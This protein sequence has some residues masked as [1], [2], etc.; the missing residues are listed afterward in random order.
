MSSVDAGG[1]WHRHRLELVDVDR[2]HRRA[3]RRSCAV[4]ESWRVERAAGHDSSRRGRD[5]RRTDGLHQ[6]CAMLSSQQRL[7]LYSG[8]LL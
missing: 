8:G 5:H 2:R 7:I 4:V 3:R 1:N 6:A